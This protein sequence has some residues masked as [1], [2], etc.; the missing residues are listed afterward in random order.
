MASSSKPPFRRA[1]YDSEIRK[2]Y[3]DNHAD[4]LLFR[5]LRRN[6]HVRLQSYPELVLSTQAITQHLN[7]IL[8][9]VGVFLRIHNGAK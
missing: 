4:P 8:V 2:H 9:F 1:L 3:A 7:S 5:D 6:T